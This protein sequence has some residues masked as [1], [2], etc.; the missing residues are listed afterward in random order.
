MDHH[1][2]VNLKGLIDL[3]SNHLYSGP[4]VFVRELLQNAVDAI[5][6][7]E[8]DEA[9]KEQK[10]YKGEIVLELIR[11][12][13]GKPATLAISENGIGLT[14][15]E[16][17][18]LLAT[19]GESS[20]RASKG[21]GPTDFLGQ[22]GIGL[23]ACF[24]VTDEIVVV[25]RSARDPEAPAME[26]RGRADGAYTIKPLKGAL[27]AGTQVFLTCK[28]GAEE[29]F[30]A[31]RLEELA[32]GYGGL[33]PYPIRLIAGK[34]NRQINRELPAWRRKFANQ[35]QR[36]KALLELGKEM[37]EQKFFDAI[38]LNIKYQ[39]IQAG[40]I[41]GVAFVLDHAPQVTSKPVHRVY[42]KNMYLTERADNLLPPWAYFVKLVVNTSGLKPTASR[43]GF[44]EDQTL[45]KARDEIGACLKS[46]LVDLSQ[47][48]PEKLAQL[49]SLHEL[50]LKA[51]AVDDDEFYQ[52]ILDWLPVETSLGDM[53]L[54]EYRQRHGVLRYSPTVD[55]FRQISQVASAQGICVI[56]AGYIHVKKLMDKFPHLI[57]G[58]R[59]EQVD[60][61][62][63]TNSFSGIP[64]SRQ[65]AGN[66]FE[67][68]ANKVLK[69]FQCH[70]HLKCFAPAEL[71]CLYTISA[72]GL[73]R[74]S[75]QQT[76]DIAKPLWSS[77]LGS[78]SPSS[79]GPAP[80]ASLCFNF[81]NPIV[82]KLLESPPREVSRRAIELLYVQALLLGHHPLQSREMK[83]LNEGLLGM[84]EAGLVS[85]S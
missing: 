22:F 6:A 14:E 84:I 46:Y 24:L 21:E 5:R 36:K 83:L 48:D 57:E 70:A 63:L 12:Q 79:S 10:G 53:T 34:S 59:A 23:L 25:T 72:E 43:E 28:E 67:D 58:G 71:P 16:I 7:R 74:R 29:W 40:E 1:F 51:L 38:P 64:E 27:D 69:A 41:D 19:I 9:E 80:F 30:D 66:R 2:Q 37:F 44:Q 54:G 35:A 81:N 68:L 42:L 82:Q 85:Q 61:S 4:E 47:N 78:L 60:S 20:K 32:R 50:T 13:P 45:L 8:I 15:E 76:M 55:E 49:I 77:V 65:E 17:H 11:K 26:W 18:R 56:N 75:V 62:D 3:L 33:L 52:L 39:D 31:G 73:L